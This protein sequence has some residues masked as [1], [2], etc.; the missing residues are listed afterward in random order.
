MR[1][2][3]FEDGTVRLQARDTRYPGLGSTEMAPQ[4]HAGAAQVAC[5]Q[6]HVS[7]WHTCMHSGVPRGHARAG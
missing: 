1:R 7:A 3:C 2:P 5:P 4:Q 6:I